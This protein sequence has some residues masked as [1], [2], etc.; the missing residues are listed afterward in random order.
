MQMKKILCGMI[1]AMMLG[2]LAGCANENSSTGEKI[3]ISAIHMPKC[4]FF[5]TNSSDKTESSSHT[6]QRPS[7]M[8]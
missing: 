2:S 5:L 8:R 6:A 7:L 1:A 4:F 3:S